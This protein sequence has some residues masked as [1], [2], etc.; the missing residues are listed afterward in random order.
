MVLIDPESLSSKFGSKKPQ[1]RQKLISTTDSEATRGKGIEL[2]D[3]GCSA[4]VD[5]V[6][7]SL[8]PEYLFSV[9]NKTH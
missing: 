3:N 8:Q 9:S 4:D 6:Y 1:N 7:E 2:A 5:C